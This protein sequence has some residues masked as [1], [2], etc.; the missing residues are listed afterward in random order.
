MGVVFLYAEGSQV[1]WI[2]VRGIVVD[3]M[4]IYADATTFAHATHVSVCNQNCVVLGWRD[5]LSCHDSSDRG[6]RQ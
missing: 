5:S 1:T 6:N 2:I 3:V 4:N